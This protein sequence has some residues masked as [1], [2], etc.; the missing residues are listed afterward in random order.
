MRRCLKWT[1]WIACVCGIASL[2]A[3]AAPYQGAA[4][5]HF[6]GK[7]FSNPGVV[8]E[9]SVL[10]YLW[11]RLTTRQGAWPEKVSL[12]TTLSPP[13][14][15]NDGSARVALIGHA[16]V[17][18]QVAGL[19]ILTD[20]IWS[21]RASML[22][23]LGPK[24]VSLPAVPLQALPP[25][26]VVLISHNHYDH[27]DLPTLRQLHARDQPR[28]IVPLG[29]AALVRSAMP[30]S[31]VSE[32]DWGETVTVA[33]PAGSALIHLEPMQH[34]SGR[35]PFDQMQTLWSAYVIEAAGLKICFVGDAGYGDGRTFRS[36]AKK[37]G[38]F[39]LLLLPIG[40]YEPAAFMADSHMS[41]GEAVTA[42]L[43]ANARRAMAHHFETFQLGFEDFEAP[44]RELMTSL[45]KHSIDA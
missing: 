42:M 19:N 17:L 30:K 41:P 16:T 37:H 1:K 21:D 3:C 40:A 6:D 9:S 23:W 31:L 29:N 8:K 35:S 25:I 45:Q 5:P 10:G 2:V 38:A 22:D 15:V 18:I 12:P 39:D 20:P 13:L 33:T 11:L 14:A 28:V 32:H 43:D 44:R 36:A 7:V 4:R 27:L 24:R 26:H 34:G